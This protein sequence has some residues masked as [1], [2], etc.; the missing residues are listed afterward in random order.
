MKKKAIK[1]EDLEKDDS[2]IILTS[3]QKLPLKP[4]STAKKAATTQG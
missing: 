1:L 2:L 3:D 4:A